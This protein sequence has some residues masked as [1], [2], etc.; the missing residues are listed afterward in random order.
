MIVSGSRPD[1]RM[2]GTCSDGSRTCLPS[3]ARAIAP[4][5]A[6]VVPQQPPTMLRKPASANS[7]STSAVCSGSSSYSPNALGSPAFG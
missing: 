3:T 1:R 7:A 6:G 4:M 2:T 5:W